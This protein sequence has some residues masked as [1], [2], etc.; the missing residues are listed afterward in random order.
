MLTWTSTLRWA[1]DFDLIDAILR[2]IP[3][4]VTLGVVALLVYGAV[5]QDLR[6]SANDPQIQIA[7][8]AAVALAAGQTSESVLPAERVDL[9]SNL[10]PFVIV[11]DQYGAV[12]ASSATLSGVVPALPAGVLGDVAKHGENRITWQPSPHV[13]VA[14]VIVPYSGSQPGFVLAGR[15]LRLIEEREDD[16]L[17]VVGAGLAAGLAV[18]LLSVLVPAVARNRL[19]RLFANS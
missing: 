19:R 14:A 9:G 6:Q 1:R 11:Y 17:A 12:R 16:L 8:N 10:A 5:Q 7:E 2:W 15:S 13:R 3:I 4:A 18:T